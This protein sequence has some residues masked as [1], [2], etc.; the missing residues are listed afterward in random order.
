MKTAL[1]AGATGLVGSQLLSI[2][3]ESN[4]YSR[5][6]AL[7]RKPIPFEHPKL[8]QIIVDFDNPDNALLVADDVFCCLG[9]TIKKAG[10]RENF[11]KVDLE[12]PIQLA[13]AT[14]S[15]GTKKFAL[16]SAMG[17]NT[18]SMFFYNRIK[19]EVE[20]KLQTIPF[21]TILIVRPSLLLGKRTEIRF[22]E[23]MGK[24]FMILF[25]F[26]IPR[27]IKG[28]DAKK[29]AQNMYNTLT[30]DTNGLIIND[31]GDMQGS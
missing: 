22:G 9:T 4:Y 5:V 15:N 12:Y 27:N 21:E 19:G 28:I 24:V 16:V 30:E 13:K 2:L 17:S 8:E 26:L 18:K 20:K 3:L 29:V 31:S 7:V 11:K 25:G 14:F 6:K 1:I 23:E 10:S